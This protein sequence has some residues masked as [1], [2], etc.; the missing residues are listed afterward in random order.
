MHFIGEVT[1]ALDISLANLIIILILS[2]I[3]C[4]CLN[5]NEIKSNIIKYYCMQCACI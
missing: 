5:Q 4:A 2:E 1:N 3:L